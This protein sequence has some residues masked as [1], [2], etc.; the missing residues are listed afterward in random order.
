MIRISNTMRRP[1]RRV[2]GLYTDDFLTFW[3]A[4]PRK[5]KKLAAALSWSNQA[6]GLQTVLAALKWQTRSPEWLAE[7]GAYVPHPTTYL[8]QRRWEDEP[9]K[10]P[11]VTRREA[12]TIA[13]GDQWLDYHGGGH[14]RR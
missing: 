12:N 14:G 13:A 8:N 10:I 11:I 6:P 4:Y 9:N 2:T 1:T 3:E 5:V 7:G